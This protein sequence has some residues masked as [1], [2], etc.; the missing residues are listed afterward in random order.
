MGATK[1]ASVEFVTGSVTEGSAFGP[2]DTSWVEQPLRP[3]LRRVS[4][5]TTAPSGLHRSDHDL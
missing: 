1:D 4:S 3:Q 5:T 2:D